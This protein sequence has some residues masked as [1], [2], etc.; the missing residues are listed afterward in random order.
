MILKLPAQVGALPWVVRCW[1]FWWVLGGGQSSPRHLVRCRAGAVC[2][3]GCCRAPPQSSMA[4]CAG[5]RCP[6]GRL[7]S[8]G[9]A[10]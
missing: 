6:L 5:P 8:L 2:R 9:D 7:F 1:W 3:V 4:Q 10:R